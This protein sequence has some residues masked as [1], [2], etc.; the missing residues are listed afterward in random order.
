MAGGSRAL[1]WIS[2]IILLHSAYSTYDCEPIFPH[3][4]WYMNRLY[5]DL[6]QLKAADRP[7]DHIPNDVSLEALVSLA[8]FILGTVL[9]AP[10][11]VEITWAK[12]MGK[13]SIDEMDSRLGFAGIKHR[14]ATFFGSR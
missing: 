7:L 5:A 11:M 2:L 12:E 13:R 8:L 9:A 1:Q 14:G 6:T 4:W 3:L 10:K